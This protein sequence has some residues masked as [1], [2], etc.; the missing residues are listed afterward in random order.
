[1]AGYYRAAHVGLVLVLL[2]TLAT[3]L[4][5]QLEG[6]VD[7][8]RPSV[9]LLAVTRPG[10]QGVGAGS[11]YFV[12]AGGYVLTARHVIEG[13]NRIVMRTQDGKE[14]SA[15]VV[16]YSTDFDAAVLRVEGEG[17][18]VLTFGDSDTIR[19]GSEVL[20]FGYPLSTTM[21]ASTFTVTRGIVSAIRPGN[22][23]V[24]IDAALNP[25]NSGGPVVNLKGE[26]IGIAVS[27]YW[28]AAPCA[29]I[30]L[31]LER[32]LGGPMA[33]HLSDLLQQ[34]RLLQG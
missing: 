32:D 9:V 26:V 34:D 1:M 11:G 30:G 19:Q 29:S 27:G 21:G 8:V 17:F 25:G 16:R 23:G 6:I 10:I 2:L 20:V 7:R 15:I 3:P 28:G 18:A 14:L 4:H 5:A 13:T 12:D 31:P 24:Q 33:V 22:E